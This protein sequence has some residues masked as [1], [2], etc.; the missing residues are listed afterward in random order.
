MSFK[1]FECTAGLP[2]YGSGWPVCDLCHLAEAEA[3]E[4]VQQDEQVFGGPESVHRIV[5]ES[6]VFIGGDVVQRVRS[7]W[8]ATVLFQ[9]RHQVGISS[10]SAFCVDKFSVRDSMEPG[11]H[12]SASLVTGDTCP[13][14]GK[15]FLCK[16]LGGGLIA[17]QVGEESI[18]TLV[19]LANGLFVGAAPGLT[20]ISYVFYFFCMPHG[21]LHGRCTN[22]GFAD[23]YTI[24]RVGAVRCWRKNTKVVKNSSAGGSIL[25]AESTTVRR[26][27]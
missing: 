23:D 5:Q 25:P 21:R 2:L 3:L 8:F 24:R 18:Y 19:V 13:G 14:R 4:V 26:Y 9:L 11:L 6:H 12:R 22:N 10:E 27:P 1:F 7:L 15:G 20:Q 16:L 17:G